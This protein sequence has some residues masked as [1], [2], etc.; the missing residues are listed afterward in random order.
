MLDLR[1]V[2][3]V[4]G[5][6]VAVMG[7]TMLV[8]LALDVA[9]GNGHWPVFLESA[10]ITI[11]IG[12][13][14]AL[15]C[16]NGVKEGLTI[17]Q[18]FLLTTGVW[19]ALPVFGALPFMIGATQARF[20]DALFES[21]SGMTTTG[22]TVFAGLD[23]LPESLLLWRGMLQ[24]YGGLGVV[25]LALI[26]LPVMR[27]GGMQFF[28]SES[29]D[30]LGK[31]LPR[32][33]DISRGILNVYIAL[34]VAA[35]FAYIMAGMSLLDAVVH[36]MTTISTGGFS[37]SDQSFAA[38]S[39]A[40]QYA[41]VVFM[42]LGSLPFVLLMQA[43]KGRPLLFFRDFQA[44]AYLRWL[45]YACIAVVVFSVL[46][47]SSLTEPHVRA[48]IFNTVSIF[49]GTGYGSADVTAWGSAAFAVLFIVGA[50][51]GCTGST[52]CSIKVFRYQVLIAGIA[53]QVQRIRHP[54]RL[55]LPKLGG[56]RVGNDVFS[57]IIVVFSL[58]VLT[59]GVVTVALG[60]TELN[61]IES[62]TAAWTS[63]FNIGPAF[64]PSVGP[65]GALTAFPDAAKWIMIFAM[66]LGRLEI[67]S[68]L[69]IFT[70]R[71][72]RD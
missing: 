54:N 38:F 5:L 58:Y 3:Y 49:S 48:V 30:T 55:A 60:L 2:G 11:L 52:G 24:W 28:R 10:V 50:I 71:F 26:F 13:L 15:S 34:T 16:A 47:A 17:Q 68:V 39:P 21:M 64:G 9:V 57:S 7:A 41:C 69:V 22:A 66:L 25:I 33:V 40:A 65:T 23:S 12:T 19:V 67:V 18:A 46:E 45:T 53:S 63:I 61:F 35:T 32:T 8:P 62:V 72:W 43:A 14:V 4:I 37:T 70:I 27:V 20:T 42:I 36:A 29:F 51:G 31:A 6:L 59:F 56:K 44:S 1:P